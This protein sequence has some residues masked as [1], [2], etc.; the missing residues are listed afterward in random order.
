MSRKDT[1]ISESG[2]NTKS[3][4]SNISA[5]LCYIQSWK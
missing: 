4:N 3:Q 1:E 5:I 2:D